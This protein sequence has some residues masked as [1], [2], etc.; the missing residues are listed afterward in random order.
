M[1]IMRLDVV[2]DAREEEELADDAA[3]LHRELLAL[4]GI[5]VSRASTS[6][7]A[8]GTRSPELLAIGAFLVSLKPT[9]EQLASVVHAVRGWLQRRGSHRTIRL[10][11]D[12]DVLEMTGATSDVQAKLADQWIRA[13]TQ[14]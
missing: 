1:S 2:D 8:D 10:E 6:E 14:A 3:S 9:L 11:L 4:D 12:G 5:E 7:P 13:H